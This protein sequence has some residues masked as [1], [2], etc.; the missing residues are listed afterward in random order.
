[1]EI[2]EEIAKEVVFGGIAGLAVGLA[3]K[4][5]SSQ[6]VGAALSSSF[7]LMRV[8]IFE[9]HHLATWSPLIVDDPSFT[10][11]LKRKARREVTSVGSRV[12]KFTTEN[13]LI[14]G[15]FAGGYFLSGALHM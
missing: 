11:H 10:S 1:M 12:E 8:A 7:F 3:A 14:I 4:H 5:F 9:G 15:S 6:V 13:G 2:S